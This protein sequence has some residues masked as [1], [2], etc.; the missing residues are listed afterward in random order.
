MII[1]K[2]IVYEDTV[3]S[4]VITKLKS[5][6]LFQMFNKKLKCEERSDY[7][8]TEIV[9][10]YPREDGCFIV[11]APS[12]DIKFSKE[13]KYN[14]ITVDTPPEKIKSIAKT[15]VDKIL[16]ITVQDLLENG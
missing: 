12:I 13:F 4:D 9:D 5:A 6:I 15:I 7:I 8:S 16:D 1:T 14:A 2:N 3:P 10:I 11:S